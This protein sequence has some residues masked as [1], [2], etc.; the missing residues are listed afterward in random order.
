V[1]LN[2]LRQ[3]DGGRFEQVLLRLVGGHGLGVR[4]PGAHLMNQF[5][6]EFT[7]K[8]IKVKYKIQLWRGVALF[9]IKFNSVHNYQKHFVYL[10]TTTLVGFDLTAHFFS[11]VP[12]M[13]LDR[14]V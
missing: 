11:R 5:R 10:N 12:R 9:S 8:L 4:H 6:P 1:Y 13:P 7:S 3:P 2:V 14:V